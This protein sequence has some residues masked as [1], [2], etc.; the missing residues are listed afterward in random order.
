M[1]DYEK[2]AKMIFEIDA[3]IKVDKAIKQVYEK[4]YQQM[5]DAYIQAL[6]NVYTEDE[7]K[8]MF[9]IYQKHSWF[10]T[11]GVQLFEEYMNMLK[12]INLTKE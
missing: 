2:F 5:L 9:D 7:V 1:N 11:K 12:K 8:I 6:K 10:I 4:Y 3:K